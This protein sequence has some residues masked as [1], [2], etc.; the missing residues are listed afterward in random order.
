MT[1]KSMALAAAITASAMAMTGSPAKA[2][3]NPM[4]GEIMMVGFDFCPR[5]WAEADGQL[6]PTAQNEYLYNVLGTTYGGDG[7]TTFGLPDLRGRVA[8]GQG[9][10]RDLYEVR[11]GEQFGREEA[12]PVKETDRDRAFTPPVLVVR[13]CIATEGSFPQRY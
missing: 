1:P 3:N 8:M 7:R 10:G 4:L 5:G 2:G 11:I 6:L 12:A 9:R 13:Y